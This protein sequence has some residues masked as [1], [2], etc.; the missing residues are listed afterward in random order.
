VWSICS[1]FIRIHSLYFR[2]APETHQKP[3]KACFEQF[4]GKKEQSNGFPGLTWKYEECILMKFEQIDHTCCWLILP[5]SVSISL[6]SPS[7]QSFYCFFMLFIKENINFAYFNEKSTWFSS[8]ICFG[9]FEN[10]WNNFQSFR[11]GCCFPSCC[12]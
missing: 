3:T 7:R 8:E 4:P 9:Y 5:F 6:R 12:R 10:I 2:S 11:V 1:N